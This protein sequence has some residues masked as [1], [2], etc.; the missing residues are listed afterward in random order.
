MR[1]PGDRRDAIEEF[2][3]E[4]DVGIVEHTLLQGDHNELGIREVLPDH[5]SNVLCVA[6]VKR[7]IHLHHRCIIQMCAQYEVKKVYVLA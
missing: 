2:G 5:A 3:A 6:E 4:D 7:C 1:G